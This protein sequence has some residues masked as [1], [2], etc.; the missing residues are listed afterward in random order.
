MAAQ[1]QQ[2]LLRLF[3]S[4]N[5][6][7]TSRIAAVVQRHDGKEPDDKRLGIGSRRRMAPSDREKFSIITRQGLLYKELALTDDFVYHGDSTRPSSRYGGEYFPPG[8]FTTLAFQSSTILMVVT[9]STTSFSL[10]GGPRSS[11]TTSTSTALLV[12]ES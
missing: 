7:V 5:G 8:R 11:T 10:A 9:R 12:N 4:T 2:P 6:R 1:Q 3:P